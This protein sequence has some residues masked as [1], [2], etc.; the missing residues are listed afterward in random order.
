MQKDFIKGVET[1]NKTVLESVKRLAEINGK[2][3]ERATERQLAL[4]ADYMDAAV[5]QMG[6][7]GDMKDVQAVVAAQSKLV[8]EF[9]E[10]LVA[11]AKKNAEIFEQTKGEYSSWLE[12]GIKQASENPLAKQVVSATKKAA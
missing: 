9:G 5:R 2:A 11:H 3:V 4:T 12:E 8:S 7:F 6:L 10:K 1:L